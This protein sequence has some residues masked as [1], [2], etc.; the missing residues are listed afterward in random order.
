APNRD[1]SIEFLKFCLSAEALADT[2]NYISYGPLRKSSAAF[3]NPDILPHLPTA[4]DNFKTALTYDIE[5]WAD[6]VD[7]LTARFNSW[8]AK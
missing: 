5:F 6:N 2:T 1:A 8:L 7:E 3:V 4:P